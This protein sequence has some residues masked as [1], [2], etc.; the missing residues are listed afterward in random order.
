MRIAGTSSDGKLYF[1]T[2][3]KKHTVDE[4]LAFPTATVTMQGS[5]AYLSVAGRCRIRRDEALIAKLWSKDL[6]S[7]LDGDPEVA[8]AIE[9]HP[10]VAEFWSQ[11]RI[12]RLRHLW[13]TDRNRWTHGTMG[14]E[15]FGM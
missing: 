9:F 5:D 14:A 3:W 4:I 6:R 13:A 10:E 1:L 2:P 15:S 7:W 11:G 12:E 8:A